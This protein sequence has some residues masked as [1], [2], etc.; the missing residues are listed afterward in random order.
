MSTTPLI[1]WSCLV[2]GLILALAIKLIKAAYRHSGQ[3]HLIE[4]GSEREEFFLPGDPDPKN[5][6]SYDGPDDF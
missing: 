2:G 1:T 6:D 3:H 4:L 5:I